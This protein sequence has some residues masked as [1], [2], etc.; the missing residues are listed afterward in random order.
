M[1]TILLNTKAVDLM[2]QGNLR[3]ASSGLREALNQHEDMNLTNRVTSTFLSVRSVPL[4]EES[5]SL[6]K[7]SSYQDHHA[8]S[9][10]NRALVIDDAE[11]A[12]ASSIAGQNCTTAVVM[13]NMGLV[14]QLQGIKDL[15][16]QQQ[17]NFK[18]AMIFYQM[19]TDVLEGCTDPEQQVSGLVYLAVLNNM[20][21]IYSHFCHRR[22]TQHCLSR[23]FTI[24]QAMEISDTNT[25]GDEFLPFYLNVLVL[26]GQDGVAAAAA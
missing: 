13:Y 1:D 15:R 5:L 8:F 4:E 3:E 22:E 12:A 7:S 11:L 25:L 23:L 10:F 17:A 14:H 24:L 2:R 18:T 26:L 6:L 20:G 21:H 16:S 19:A 9:V